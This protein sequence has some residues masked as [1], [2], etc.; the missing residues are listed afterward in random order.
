MSEASETNL[1]ASQEDYL[2]AIA[3]LIESHGHAHTSDIAARL[4]VRMPSVT[5]ALGLLSR[6]GYVSYRPNF[7]V[8]LTRQ[9]ATEAERVRRRHRI[10]EEFFRRLLGLSVEQAGKAACRI[11]HIIDEN[12]IERF[13][14]F[15]EAVTKR[16]DCRALRNYL[17]DAFD[18]RLSPKTSDCRVLASLDGGALADI[19]LHGRNIDDPEPLEKRGAAPETELVMEGFDEREGVYVCRAADGTRLRFSPEEA[20][21]IW[22]TPRPAEKT[23]PDVEAYT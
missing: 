17:S 10:L 13:R 5:N 11:E 6:N 14:I 15:S 21:N 23:C 22:V 16:R 12:T 8:T 1:S 7:P 9:G 4:S 18:I 3:E 2:E 20:E 19:L